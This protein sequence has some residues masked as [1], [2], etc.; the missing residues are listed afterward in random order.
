MRFSCK[1]RRKERQKDKP[2]SFEFCCGLVATE[3]TVPSEA[4]WEEVNSE[5][6]LG[7]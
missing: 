5:N 2:K 4:N 7:G 6:P 1:A 3:K